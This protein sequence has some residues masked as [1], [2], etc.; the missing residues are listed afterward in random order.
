MADFPNPPGHPEPP[1]PA[2]GAP[3]GGGNWRSWLVI[4]LVVIGGL[5]YLAWVRQHS[6]QP[7]A[8]ASSGQNSKLLTADPSQVVGRKAPDWTLPTP[9]GKM[10]SLAQFHGHPIV[11]DFWASWCGPCKLEI[12]W[13]NKLQAKYRNRGLVVIGVSEDLKLSDLKNYLQSHA[14]DYPVV[15]ADSSIDPSYGFPFGL[16]TTLFIKPDGTISS[17]VVGLEDNAD[18][19]DHVQNI[20]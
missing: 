17:L 16:P 20:L 8:A 3:A 18:L 2:A 19:Q 9:D 15:V 7:P 6:P 5:A 12:P 1:P 14:L 10:L 4:G 13:W 11:L